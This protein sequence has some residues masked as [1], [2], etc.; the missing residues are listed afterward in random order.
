MWHL[1]CLPLNN[2]LR[3]RKRLVLLQKIPVHLS[4]VSGLFQG[5]SPIK[6]HPISA[7]ELKLRFEKVKRNINF[8]EEKIKKIEEQTRC[9]SNTNL[10]HHRRHPRITATKCYRIA[11]QRE[12]TSPTKIIQAVLDY[13]EPFQSKSMQEGLEMGGQCH[14]CLQIIKARGRVCWH[15]CTKMWLLYFQA[16]WLPWSKS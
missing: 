12:T 7:E 9:Q 14:C 13:K 4:L 3:R 5:I 1:H 11:V 10:W 15:Y 8:D 2:I 6:Y 16:S